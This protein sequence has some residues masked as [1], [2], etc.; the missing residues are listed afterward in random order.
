MIKPQRL[1]RGDT[2]AIVSLSSGIGGESVFKHRYEIGKRRLE[3]EFGLNV[4]AMPNALKGIKYPDKHPE[5]RASDLMEAF[6]DDSI[7][8]IITMI[9]GNDTIRLLPY[10]NFETIQKNP[11]IFM[12]YSDTT[13][14][15]FMMYKAGLTSFYGPCIFMEFAENV[16]MHDYTKRYIVDTLFDTK[17]EMCINPSPHWTSEFLDW[18]DESNNKIARTMTADTKGFELL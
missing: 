18:A 10:I 13:I 14:N 12:G 6:E 11:K 2:V 9:G 1:K 8:A 16:A 5:A 3:E 4:I 7:K 17:S 15:H